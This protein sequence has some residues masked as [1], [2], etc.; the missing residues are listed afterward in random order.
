MGFPVGLA[1]L[2]GTELSRSLGNA[3]GGLPFTALL[4]ARG[5]VIQRKAGETRQTELEGWLR[6]L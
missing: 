1:A 2:D 5:S 6:S 3:A 4:D